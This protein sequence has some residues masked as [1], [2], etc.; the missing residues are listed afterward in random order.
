MVT[1]VGIIPDVIEQSESGLMGMAFHPD[2]PAQPYVYFVHSYDRS[3]NDIR[4]RLIRMRFDGAELTG[5]EIL[6][7]D[8]PGNLNHNGSR[9][10]IGPDRLIYMTTGDAQGPNFA[11]DLP[12]LAGK[13]LRL[14]LDGRVPADNPFRTE[15]YSFGHRNAQ[16]LVFHPVTG[17]LY[18][19]EHGP[20]TNDEV[21][22]I[23]V[24]RHYGWPEV[25]GYCTDEDVP[26]VP[27]AQYC[28]ENNVMEP[29][30]AW[31]PT[32]APAGADFYMSDAIPTWKGDLFFTTLKGQS[33]H[34]L[35]L[36]VDG[37]RAASD[38]VLFQGEFG[39]L[40]DVAVGPRGEISA[41]Q[42]G[43]Q[44]AQKSTI[45]ILPSKSDSRTVLP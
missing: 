41:R 31:T 11:I 29:V 24:G 16:G 39:R 28:N 37:R 15:V 20:N 36:S 3:G 22:Q 13:V 8:I 21:N 35:T 23:V 34:R 40:R 25:H 18:A 19:T 9:L 42:G 45:L 12:S 43:H 44:V 32:I 2:F 1:R 14:T 27:E 4:N 5:R 38:E 26:G 7:Q 33:L 6:L 17:A 30:A 10:V